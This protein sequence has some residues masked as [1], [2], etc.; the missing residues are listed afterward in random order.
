MAT[1]AQEF[2]FVSW[3]GSNGRRACPLATFGSREPQMLN[4]RLACAEP[5][6]ADQPELK[7][8]A[9]LRGAVALVVRGG[10]SFAHK[11]R[12]LQR[13]GAVAML[14]ANNTREEPLAAFTMG[15]SSEELEDN[16]K[17]GAEP[18]T[19]PC[20][21]MCLRD[22]RELFQKF[23]PSVKNGELSFEI[24]QREDGVVVAETCLRV[25][26]ELYDAAEAGKGWEAIKRTTTS[27][28]KLLEPQNATA[29]G[30]FA[31]EA[32]SVA[33][34]GR[35]GG[36]TSVK[37]ESDTTTNREQQPPLLAFVQWA[38]SASTYEICF[39]P[40]ADFCS[41]NAGALYTGRLVACDPLLADK[42]LINA[43]ELGGAVALMRRGSCSFPEKLERVQ[44]AGA[45]AAIV[46][47]DDEED[48]DAAFVMSVDHID[49]ANATLPAVMISHNTFL[50]IQPALN[51]T[52]ARILCLA[53]EAADGLLAS[54]QKTVSFRDL[55]MP[56]R[57]DQGSSDGVPDLVF[58]LHVACRDGDHAACQRILASVEGKEATR[59]LVNTSCVSTGLTALHQA[60][61]GGNDNVVEL[62]LQLGATPDAVD[63]AMQT[64]LHVACANTHVECARL[65]LRA[66][67]S[68]PQVPAV[69]YNVDE[70]YGGLPTRQNIGGGTAMHEASRAGSSECVELLLS[71]NARVESATDG[72][73]DKYLFLGVSAK[74]L[75]GRTPLHLACANVHAECTLYLVAANADVNIKDSRGRSPLLLACEAANDPAK[76]GDAV[77]IIEKLI[78]S[79]AVV[80]ECDSE[81][82]SEDGEDLLLDRIESPDLR[83]DLEVLYLRHEAQKAKQRSLELGKEIEAVNKRI[84]GLED[85]LTTLRSQVDRHDAYEN[86]IQQL[87][88]Q[89]QMILQFQTSHGQQS[90][91]VVT[92][93][94]ATSLGDANRKSDE[95]LA[96]DAALARD[97]GKKC[98]R[99]SQSVLAEKYFQRSLEL[100]PLPGVHRL[101][102]T[103]R[104]S[105]HDGSKDNL[106][107][108]A[109]V[110]V[111]PY[112]NGLIVAPSSRAKASKMQQLLDMVHKTNAT[113]QARAMLDSELNKLKT[114]SDDAEFA[115]ACRWV[116]WLVALPWGDP[117]SGLQ[118]E[119]LYA[120]K[121]NEFQQLDAI[122]A[123]RIEAHRS[124]AARTIQRTFRK[125]YAVHLRT[126]TVAAAQI[127][128]VIRGKL[129]RLQYEVTRKQLLE[130]RDQETTS[131]GNQ[132][133]GTEVV[134]LSKVNY[135]TTIDP[136]IQ[137][138]LPHRYRVD[139]LIVGH[140]FTPGQQKCE[141]KCAEGNT[142]VLQLIR[143]AEIDTAL[144]YKSK[145]DKAQSSL[146]VWTRWGAD[147]GKMCACSL[148]G[149][150]ENQ[151]DAQRRFDRI[152]YEEELHSD[153]LPEDDTAYESGFSFLKTIVGV[154]SSKDFTSSAR[155]A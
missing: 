94:L 12:L 63:L 19:I 155:S 108:G 100:M 62:L 26:R 44:R 119:D 53:G 46:C 38:T 36:Q 54:S 74:D 151:Q 69:L 78:A 18:I 82:N 51:V 89:M 93:L 133:D 65:L 90:S 138:K 52:T 110:V 33:N 1:A 57:E 75:E 40:L 91:S 47:N 87:Q 60:C 153:A 125:C 6:R 45:V 76:E 58:D 50:R 71:A 99:Q 128:A 139:E 41:A 28:I 29:S 111:A 104:S 146:F 70:E 142:R 95:E 61:A 2:A 120:M 32:P 124:Q 141:S 73:T 48:L 13:A 43:K 81:R 97:L 118:N 34:D 68:A 56:S 143:C 140:L 37:S 126:R 17:N 20:V 105:T 130:A 55:L 10:C 21:M 136:C 114:L 106:A 92:P 23:P 123:R 83:R 135:A 8:A 84:Q 27:I 59:T 121:R 15:E 66:E 35:S 7:N 112:T 115:L 42:P 4:V 137:R 122:D 80:E 49:A 86:Q 103:A 134:T 22:V 129:A 145:V 16:K 116:E 64:P 24:L 147:L 117:T 109:F 9:E 88:L 67:S 131:F 132:Q 79:G 5:P 127:Q 150:Y 154:G 149:P 31:V 152:A 101:L 11:A 85:E 14:L 148:S 96:L 113:P 98:L 77:Q 30:S 102:D 39:A 25:Q 144:P 72:A 3:D 107:A